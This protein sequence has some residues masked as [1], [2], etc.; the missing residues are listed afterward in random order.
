MLRIVGVLILV[1]VSLCHCGHIPAYWKQQELIKL[2]TPYSKIERHL[3]DHVASDDVD[4]N[5]REAK[6]WLREEVTENTMKKALELFVSMDDV[7]PCTKES[8]RALEANDWLC[9][10]YADRTQF[11][12]EHYAMKHAKDCESVYGKILEN[13]YEKLDQFTIGMA[14]VV[15]DWL[16]YQTDENCRLNDYE[17]AEAAY[18][19]VKTKSEGD[20][21][22][23]CLKGTPSKRGNKI[24]DEEKAKRLLNKYLVEPCQKIIETNHDGWLDARHF[25]SNRIF[26]NNEAL[27]RFDRGYRTCK[28]L[29]EKDRQMLEKNFITRAWEY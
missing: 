27:N 29:I 23:E 10:V 5:M 21:D 12:I 2:N 28:S 14:D 13:R 15:G 16:Y 6:R 7:K 3:F 11:I 24:L 17:H 26:G 18:D 25:D 19:L 9:G 22:A 4:A 1:N 8:Y 20:P